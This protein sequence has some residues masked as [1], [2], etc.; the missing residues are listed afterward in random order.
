LYATQGDRAGTCKVW[1]ADRAAEAL[2]D[3]TVRAYIREAVG[4]IYGEGVRATFDKRVRDTLDNHVSL[5]EDPAEVAKT[6]QDRFPR[7]PMSSLRDVDETIP[8]IH[9][10]QRV[11]DGV[12]Q[13][14]GISNRMERSRLQ[15]IFKH[16]P[17]SVF[18]YQGGQAIVRSSAI[19]PDE[20]THRLGA[21]DVASVVPRIQHLLR[22][23]DSLQKLLFMPG[24]I[25]NV[26]GRI[27]LVRPGK[28]L[29]DLYPTVL[30]C[31]A[32]GCGAAWV[33]DPYGPRG[34]D[35]PRCGRTKRQADS[36]Q[37]AHVAVHH[38]GTMENLW[39]KNC[40]KHRSAPIILERSGRG[41]TEW[42][43]VCSECGEKQGTFQYCRQATCTGARQ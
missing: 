35:C 43:W 5:I 12:L 31:Y 19:L 16:L 2:R 3:P 40:L 34:S 21:I 18:A 28:V 25:K 11:R 30:Q 24:G 32:S 36:K 29:V 33:F 20:T 7:G 14:F 42:K 27:Q 4:R 39:V 41:P 15:V 6:T 17:E 38:C 8:I 23:V 26:E 37:L 1:H 9:P 13:E 22:Q 10:S